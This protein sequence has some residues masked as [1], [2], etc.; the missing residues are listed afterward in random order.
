MF[1]QISQN[2]WA[3]DV[4]WVPDS[5]VGRRLF[6]LPN[7]MEEAEVFLEMWEVGGAGEEDPLPYLK[8]VL[9]RIVSI[10]AVIRKKR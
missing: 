3:F 5:D 10:A 2:F 7:E 6:Q 9:C 1:K 8:T 4:E